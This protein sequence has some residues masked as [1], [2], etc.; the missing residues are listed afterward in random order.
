MQ[1]LFYGKKP[2]K[3]IMKRKSCSTTTIVIFSARLYF[4]LEFVTEFTVPLHL[5]N[6]A[7]CAIK[8]PLPGFLL[9]RFRSTQ[10][11]QSVASSYYRQTRMY[12]IVLC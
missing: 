6:K 12:F 3:L 11:M 9:R 5:F 4:L 2:N 1:L 8:H 10:M 7:S